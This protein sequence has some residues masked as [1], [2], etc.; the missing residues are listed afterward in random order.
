MTASC[1]VFHVD[2]GCVKVSYKDKVFLRPRNLLTFFF[3]YDSFK[4]N[5][6]TWL[7]MYCN[8]I[9]LNVPWPMHLESK[10]LNALQSHG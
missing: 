8:D 6:S 5:G 3:F 2:V 1:Y 10:Y 7:A 9:Q 4:D